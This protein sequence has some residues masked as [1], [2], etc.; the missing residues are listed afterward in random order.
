MNES[1]HFLLKNEDFPASRVSE[2]NPLVTEIQASPFS[3]LLFGTEPVYQD[4]THTL[5]AGWGVVET[6]PRMVSLC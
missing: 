5:Q 3:L 2:L 4:F 1:M 6:K